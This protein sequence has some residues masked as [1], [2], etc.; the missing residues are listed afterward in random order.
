[1]SSLDHAPV[2]TCTDSRIVL[3]EKVPNQAFSYSDH[4]GL[5]ATYRILPPKSSAKPTQDYLADDQTTQHRPLPSRYDAVEPLINVYD[6]SP[7]TSKSP[8]SP[9]PNTRLI[10]PS[11]Q[12]TLQSA[13]NTLHAYTKLSR[14]SSNRHLRLFML[15]IVFAL[16]LTVSSAWQPKSWIQPIWTLL[17]VATGALGA[18]MLYVG[19][20]WGE[21]ESNLL[22]EVIEEMEL[23][24]KVVEME[25]M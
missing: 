10:S 13:L 16:G 11:K 19:F 1:M 21:W 23:E 9:G 7:S 17:G 5:S 6:T 18:T 14:R 22:K 8:T 12:D 3:T 2:L 20:V 4:F 25:G 15:S 24:R